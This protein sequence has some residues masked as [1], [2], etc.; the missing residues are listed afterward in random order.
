[1]RSAFII[2]FLA[3]ATAPGVAVASDPAKG[4]ATYAEHCVACHAE[5]GA[6]LLPDAPDFR[7]GEGLFQSDTALIAS[8]QRGVGSMPG[9]DR[10]IADK[11]MADLVAFLRTLQ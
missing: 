9:Y 11:D 3:L 7:R 8:I 1:M 2:G 4:R 10:I 5:D 6:P